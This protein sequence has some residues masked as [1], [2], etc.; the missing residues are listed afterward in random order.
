MDEGMLIIKVKIEDKGKALEA[1]RVWEKD[2]RLN[3]GDDTGSLLA[4]FWLDD[5]ELAEGFGDID[6]SYILGES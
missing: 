2:Y 5:R 1:A 3:Y 4:D 6:E